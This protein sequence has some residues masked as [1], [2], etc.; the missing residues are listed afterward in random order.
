MS[1]FLGGGVG[2]E[3][4]HSVFVALG[5][6]C[7]NIF[8]ALTDISESEPGHGLQRLINNNSLTRGGGLKG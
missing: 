5:T 6:V 1:F 3:G 4:G 8:D 2:G 7:N